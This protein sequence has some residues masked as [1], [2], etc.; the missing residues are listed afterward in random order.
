M[1]LWVNQKI[2]QHLGGLRLLDLPVLL[3]ALGFHEVLV[4]ELAHCPPCLAILHHEDVVAASDEIG[5]LGRGA[6]A[7]VGAFLVNQLLHDLPVRQNDGGVPEAFQRKDTAVLLGPFGHPAQ[8]EH[9]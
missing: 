4:D 1:V 2:M 5:Y 9:G 3:L 7:E 6:V 8:R